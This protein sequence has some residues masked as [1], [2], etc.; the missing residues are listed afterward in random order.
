MVIGDVAKLA[1]AELMAAVS[2]KQDGYN[3]RLV[4]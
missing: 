4:A 1:K 2:S 3:S